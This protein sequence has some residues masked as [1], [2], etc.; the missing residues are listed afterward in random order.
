M[1]FACFIATVNVKAQDPAQKQEKPANP[2]VMLA[3]LSDQQKE[4]IQQRQEKSKEFRE[5]FK[6][7][8]TQEQRDILDDPRLIKQDRQRAYRASFT[9]SQVEMIKSHQAEMK[10]MSEQ[11][12]SS[13]TPAQQERM[14]QMKMQRSMKTAAVRNGNT[15]P[16]PC[17]CDP[18]GMGRQGY[19]GGNLQKQAK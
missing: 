2:R 12:R 11:F 6:A 16:C 4:M 1:V 13:L 3:D 9:D 15:R 10:K 5:A 18:R 19:A 17:P 8:I 14:K 7:T